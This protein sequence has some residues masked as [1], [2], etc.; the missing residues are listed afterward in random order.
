MIEPA[1]S[2]R[3]DLGASC[4]SL[5][6]D[7]DGTL[8][9]SDLLMESVFGLIMANPDVALPIPLWLLRGRPRLKAEVASRTL[10]D[11]GHVPLNED[12][13]AHLK[14]E[15]ASGR[16]IYLATASDERLARA[17]ADHLGLFDGVFASNGTTNLKGRHKAALLVEKFGDRGFD[18]AGDSRADLAVWKHA[19]HAIAVNA[20]PGTIR[21][22]RKIHPDATIIAPRETRLRDYLR[23]IRVHQWAKNALL[24]LP[25]LT[26]HAITA[27]NVGTLILAF[28]AFS[29]VA[30]SVYLTNDLLDLSADR[31]H[32]TKRNRPLAS[33][34]VPLIHGAAMIPV[35]LLGGLALAAAV[36]PL[37]LGIVAF[38]F[39]ITLSYSLFLKRQPVV[40]VLTLAGLYTMRV[41]AGGAALMLPLSAWLLAFSMFLF[42]CLALVKRH[43]E[44]KARLDAGKADPKGRGYRLDDIPVLGA[45]AGAAGYAA[46]VVLAL[47]VNSPAVTELYARPVGLWLVCVLLLFWVSRI[48][49][50][51]HRGDM[52]DDPVVFALK[53]RTSL[54]TVALAAL[55]AVGSTL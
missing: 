15:K 32:A 48:L 9:C 52:H 28:L 36:S 31:D 22:L 30:S 39:A 13:I 41:I 26:A 3:V 44:L 50:I 35:L 49:L 33:G 4:R 25:M 7:V 18:Y 51:S 45:L 12:L 40:D 53:D 38:Y 10:L 17:L 11:P 29:L 37:F 21:A 42:L 34:K 8:T 46:V 23:A 54:A 16:K 20:S 55:F 5:V 47:Y 2:V 27:A 1:T 6:T 24:F 43:T 14:A 19:R